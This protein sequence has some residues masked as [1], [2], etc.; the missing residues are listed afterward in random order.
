M[1]PIYDVFL[2]HS[3]ADKPAV[4]KLARKL[5]EEGIE[6]FLDKW[7]LVPGDLW[8]PGL[9]EGLRNS[10]ACIVFVGS[11]GIGP[12]Q[13]Q[14]MLVAIDR[15]AK[16]PDFRVIPVLLPGSRKP[17]G[18]PDFLAQRTWVEFPSVEDE[19]AFRRLVSGIRDEEPQ[20]GGGEAPAKRSIPYRC[21]AQPPEGWIHRSEYD[22]VLE[23]L[24]SKEGAQAGRSVGITTA[25]RGA[26]GFGKT[27][28][29]QKLCFDPKVR[30]AYPDGILW[31]TMG[32]DVT[33]SGRLSR[34][35][36]LIRWWTQ[37]EAPAFESVAA[38]GAHLRDLLA[39][40]RVLVVIDDAWK[41][42]D[43][44]PFHGLGEGSALLITTRVA[45]ALPEGSLPIPVDAM[46]SSEAISLLGLGLPDAPRG[47]M[48]SLAARLGEWALLLK[49]VNGTLRKFVRG[50]LTIPEAL[51][52]VHEDLDAEGFSA[53]DQ[54]DSESRHAAASKTILVSTKSL[55][56]KERDL[57]FDLAIFPEDEDIPLSVLERYWGLNRSATRR[58]C[59]QLYDLSLLR[60]FD[61]KQE[62]IRLHD[63]N[64]QLLMEQRRKD[65][66]ALHGRLLDLSRPVSGKWQDLPKGE[67]YLW[68]RLS[69]HLFEAGKKGEFRAFLLSFQFL[70]SKLKA[71]DINSLI[72]E[73]E[74]FASESSEL[75]L[76]QSALRLSAHVLAKDR[77]QLASQLL[78][79]LLGRKEPGLNALLEGARSWQESVWLRP[80]TGNLAQAGGALVRILEGHRGRVHAVAVLDGRRV[81]S[82]SGDRTLRV[83]NLESGETL[84][85]L[86]G[87]TSGVNA[88]TVLDGGRVLSG[89]D[90]GTLRVWDLKSGET[91][92]ILEGHTSGVNAVTVL[93]GRRAISGSSDRTLRVWD[94]ESGQTLQTLEG[95]TGW[96]SALAM[97]DGRHVVS[98]SSDGTLRVWDL[99][100]GETLQT[101][102]GH[103]SGVTAVT[104]LDG[105]RAV[106]VSGYGTLRVWD[107][108]SAQTLQTLEGHTAGAS[109]VAMLGGVR[110]VSGSQDG[111][112]RVWDLESGQT[113]QTLEGHTAMVSTVTVF[114]GGRAISGSQDGTLRVWDLDGGQTLQACEGHTY[115]VT[116]LAVLGGGRAV[117]GSFDRTL[118]VWNL[119]SGETLQT[120][121]GHTAG[122][123]ALSVLGGGRAVSGSDDRTLRVWDLES[124]KTL[125]TLQGHKDGVRAVAVFD[126]GRAVSGSY[127]RTLRVWDLESGRTLLTLRG[128]TAGVS[129][130]AVFDSGRAV[131][132]SYD[133]TLRVWDLESG[134]TLQILKGHIY[135]VNM[136]AVLGGGRVLSGSN[137]GTLRVW[138]LESGQT[139]HT[140]EGH[141]TG[142]KALAVLH[143]GRAI[144][145]SSDGTLRVWDLESG[146]ALAVMT[147]DVP[148]LAVAAS[149]DGKIIVAGD[150]LGKV[151]LFDLMEPE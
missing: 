92:Q 47:E 94:L 44:T 84:Q 4:E 11:E 116:A 130:V 60:A 87:H 117:S 14:E 147:L 141:T 15:G 78:G 10:R 115:E 72:G 151:H 103:K 132:G 42:A 119:E 18:I 59:D 120:L 81:V 39:G 20:E 43:V 82:G 88:V 108:E 73:Y 56:D 34:I 77:A 139:L 22:Q 83:W 36:D 104:V 149:P 61:Q 142:V 118:R 86:E 107:L 143:G 13:R 12:L 97:L 140:L 53:F 69:Y 122:V 67:A 89:S 101:L 98:G 148:I 114:D 45:Q 128:H 38:A 35:R 21:M 112:L 52:R 7:H 150:S 46:A 6:P 40:S 49:L 65:L 5:R 33:E 138:D 133:R 76:I 134:H 37:E 48:G 66:S 91:L 111:T 121:Q 93:G 105:Y 136:V 131:S 55:S 137:D 62:L 109:A 75:R 85:I 31:A 28:L 9:E 25:L 99:E 95:H 24:C 51:Q 23:A 41:S 54:N 100:S 27:A 3:S 2:S 68:K 135:G 90:D 16:D 26:G 70:S 146:T 144:S 110:A 106:S 64:R 102:Q 127:D 74:P 17:T 113:L 80:R 30:E 123:L 29:A 63:V 8:Q 96:V 126:G 71:T 50:G 129:A 1:S 124:G 32:E 145:G 79:H 57:F 19:N 125:Q 58:L